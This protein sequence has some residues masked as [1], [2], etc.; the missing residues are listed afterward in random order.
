MLR[1]GTVLARARHAARLRRDLERGRPQV[2]L[3]LDGTDPLTA[4]RVGGYVSAGRGARSTPGGRR[5]RGRRSAR[6]ARV[7]DR[8]PPALLVQPDARRSRLLPRR[9]RRHAAHQPL[10]GGASLGIVGE[11]ESG[12]YEQ[13]LSLP[14]TPLEIVLG[15][16]VPLVGGRLRAARVHHP[17]RAGSL[18]G[19]W[20]Q[21]SWLGL[22][23]VTLPFVLA[24]LS[25]RRPRLDAGARTRRSRCSSRSS[26]SC[27]RSC[28]PA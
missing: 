14:T 23:I 10:P 19:L 5:R 11:R 22:A 9:P 15:K 12:T 16:L 27:R 24:S 3:L 26:S 2:Q 8:R 4:A 18:F 7:A 28:S 25:D 6:G 17:R 1:R 21:G 13:M 20:P